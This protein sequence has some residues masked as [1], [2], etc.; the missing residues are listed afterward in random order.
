MRLAVNRSLARA[1]IPTSRTAVGQMTVAWT[2]LPSSSLL[3]DIENATRPA[4]A[5]L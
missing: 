2:P 4:L 3:S 5:V 1:H